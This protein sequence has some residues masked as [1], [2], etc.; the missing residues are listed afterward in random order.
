MQRWAL[1]FLLLLL[2]QSYPAE[3]NG[4]VISS[5]RAQDLVRAA[6]PSWALNAG[7][8]HIYRGSDDYVPGLYFFS[9]YG[10]TNPGGSSL[11]GHFLVDPR[12]GDLFDGV[13]CL[14]HKTVALAKLQAS[15]RKQIGLSNAEYRK[16]KRPKPPMCD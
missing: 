8:L 13:A 16:L 15:I 9:V 7:E 1:A 10:P 11:I 5:E 6:L 2:A 14:D 12:T 3:S 4:R